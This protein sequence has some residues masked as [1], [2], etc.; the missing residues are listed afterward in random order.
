ML[1]SGLGAVR[2]AALSPAKVL[3]KLNRLTRH[4]H[5]LPIYEALRSAIFCMSL[6]SC[7][8]KQYLGTTSCCLRFRSR[9]G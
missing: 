4:G 9:T 8:A 2:F 5:V 1:L 6:A 7:G 3:M